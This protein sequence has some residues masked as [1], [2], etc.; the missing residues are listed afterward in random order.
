[1]H[2]TKDKL[3]MDC[4]DTTA[5]GEYRKIILVSYSAG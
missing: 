3:G 4:V 2:K 5:D 1:M